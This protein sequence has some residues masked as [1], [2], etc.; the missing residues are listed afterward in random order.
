MVGGPF[1]YV[2]FEGGFE[3]RSKW[4]LSEE[5]RLKWKMGEHLTAPV[6]LTIGRR[7]K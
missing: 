4:K 1:E 3:L 2:A 7:E 6:T 5:L